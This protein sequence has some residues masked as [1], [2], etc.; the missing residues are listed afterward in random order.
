METSTGHRRPSRAWV[1]LSAAAVASFVVHA[2][3]VLDGFGEGDAARLVNQAA[4][5]HAAGHLTIH[6]YTARVS[7]LYLHALKLLLDAGVPLRRMP[8]I[9]N[10]TAHCSA[11]WRFRRCSGCGAASRERGPP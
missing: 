4:G 7:P 5:W 3:F 6:E 11:P 2:P 1:I 9:M 10:F 8:A